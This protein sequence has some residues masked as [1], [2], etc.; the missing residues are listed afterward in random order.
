MTNVWI[1]REIV[2]NALKRITHTLESRHQF[3]LVQKDAPIGISHQFAQSQWHRGARARVQLAFL[4]R[5]KRSK[6]AKSE[7]STS[8]YVGFFVRNVI[9]GLIECFDFSALSKMG[10]SKDSS[11]L[12]RFGK[13]VKRNRTTREIGK[14]KWKRNKTNESWF[15]HR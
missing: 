11:M 15:A 2:Y 14:K 4:Y 12:L 10:T 7:R 6:A 13:S 8:F 3:S 9:F 5:K 1:E